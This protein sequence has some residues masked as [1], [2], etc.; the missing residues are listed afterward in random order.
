MLFRRIYEL[1][2]IKAELEAEKL[3][4]TTE[5]AAFQSELDLLYLKRQTLAET[6]AQLE[7]MMKMLLEEERVQKAAAAREQKRKEAIEASIR[8]AINN[9]YNKRN[10]LRGIGRSL[11]SGQSQLN[12]AERNVKEQRVR[13]PATPPNANQMLIY[14]SQNTDAE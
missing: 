8:E 6:K 5:V 2:R 1:H 14:G 7:E 12:A 4:H 11:S 13:D 10:E 3:T 9:I